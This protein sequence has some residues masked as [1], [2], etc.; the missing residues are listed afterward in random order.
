MRN[1]PWPERRKYVPVGSRIAVL[2]ISVWPGLI[3][4]L[5]PL[6]FVTTLIRSER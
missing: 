2:A 1:E 4:H 5:A 6:A 3:A